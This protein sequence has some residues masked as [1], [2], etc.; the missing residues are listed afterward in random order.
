MHES[1]L[2]FFYIYAFWAIFGLEVKK[3]SSHHEPL[4]SEVA[5]EKITNSS[6]N[7]HVTVKWLTMHDSAVHDMFPSCFT[8][9]EQFLRVEFAISESN[10][11]LLWSFANVAIDN[12]QT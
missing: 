3:K 4:D 8:L 12:S 5:A 7:W 2:F 6:H 11:I 1:S 10:N 9:V